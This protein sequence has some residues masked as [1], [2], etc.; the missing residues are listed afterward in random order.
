LQELDCRDG[1]AVPAFC[2]NTRSAFNQA[3][4]V[5][6]LLFDGLRPG[7]LAQGC[8]QPLAVYHHCNG[9]LVDLVALADRRGRLRAHL[10]VRELLPA[11]VGALRLITGRVP[12]CQLN[13][14]LDAH[15]SA[16][17]VILL[18]SRLFMTR[19]A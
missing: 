4:Y 11:F 5:L 19:T 1:N 13:I 7:A 6:Q 17:I 12:A 15:R 3:L 16:G 8:Q 10:E 14:L 2:V 18:A 9:Q